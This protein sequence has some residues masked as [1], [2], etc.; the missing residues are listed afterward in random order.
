[1]NTTLTSAV[2]GACLRWVLVC[3]GIAILSLWLVACGPAADETGSSGNSKRHP[4]DVKMRSYTVKRASL[5]RIS[6]EVIMFKLSL[7]DCRRK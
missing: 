5:N 3:V 7:S 6:A 2:H 1:M 4:G